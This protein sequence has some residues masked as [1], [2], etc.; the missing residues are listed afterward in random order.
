[1]QTFKSS[2]GQSIYTCKWHMPMHYPEFTYNISKFI[3]IE[4]NITWQI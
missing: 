1:M 4:K 3:G 2:F